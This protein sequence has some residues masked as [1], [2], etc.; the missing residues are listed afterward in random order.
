[1]LSNNLLDFFCC[2]VCAC[3]R[4]AVCGVSVSGVCGRRAQ[5][6]TN[7]FLVL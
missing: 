2:C 5:P 7:I 1:M 3:V 4:C 6:T